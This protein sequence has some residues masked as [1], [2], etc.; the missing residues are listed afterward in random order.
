MQLA[1]AILQQAATKAERTLMFSQSIG[2]LDM[3][4]EVLRLIAWQPG[5]EYFRIDGKTQVRCVPGVGAVEASRPGAPV[6]R[7]ARSCATRARISEDIFCL[8]F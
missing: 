3:M 2:M 4:E 7:R 8:P 6:P 1:L 5:R